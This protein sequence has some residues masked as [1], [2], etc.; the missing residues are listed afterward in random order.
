MGKKQFQT[1][2]L[3]FTSRHRKGDSWIIRG[4]E[5]GEGKLYNPNGDS[6]HEKERT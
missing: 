1:P 5:T 6:Q 3:M 2:L 4:V